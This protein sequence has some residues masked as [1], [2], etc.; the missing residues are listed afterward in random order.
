ML[1]AIFEIDTPAMQDALL[2]DAS[3]ISLLSQ[4][5]DEELAALEDEL[6]FAYFTG[7]PS[8]RTGQSAVW[9]G[10]A[11]VI[12]GG[13]QAGVKLQTGGRYDP[14][15]NAWQPTATSQAPDARTLH[16]AVWTGSRMIVWGGLGDSNAVYHP[17][18]GW[19]PR[20]NHRSKDG[21]YAYN[22]SGMRS[23]LSSNRMNAK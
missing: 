4:Y 2:D 15:G 13:T 17:V 18:P 1:D 6:D 7:A 22:S 19:E 21:L 3:L 9:D 8:Q 10:N 16:T 12:W 14:V 23:P 5:S 11:M 20:P